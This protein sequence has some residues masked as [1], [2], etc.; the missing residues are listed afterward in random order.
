MAFIALI[1]G[2][3]K[4]TGDASSSAEKVAKLPE[5]TVPIMPEPR[6]YKNLWRELGD[7]FKLVDKYDGIYDGY[8]KYYLKNKKHITR[9]SKRAEPYLHFIV[10]EVK[11]RN[12]PY[13][14]ALLPFVESA[15]YPFAKS[16]ISAI[17]LWQFMPSTGHMFGLNRDWWYEGRQDIHKS[18]N[19]ALNYL[20]KLY[21]QNGNDWLL[22]LASYNGGYGN[23]LKAKR[24][25]RRKNPKGNADYWAI[26]KYLPEE[27]SNY[28]PLLLAISNIVKNQYLYDLDLY[29]IK[30][31]PFFTTIPLSQQ[32]DLQKIAYSTP[33]S[34][35]TIKILNP[36]FLRSATPPK[37]KYKLLL[38]VKS[39]IVFKE[40]IKI[41]P[42]H[43]QVN[44]AKHTI[45]EGESLSVIAEKYNTS[46][47][48]IRKLNRLKNNRIRAGKKL[49][50]P[51]TAK[52]AKRLLKQPRKKYNGKK[53]YHRV[54]HGESLWKIARYYN[55]SSRALCEWNRISIRKAL[56][57]GQRL[58]IRSS[59]Y[60][61]KISYTLLEGD[62]LWKVANKYSVSMV[63]LSNWNG[64]KKSA[65]LQP[66]TKINIWIKG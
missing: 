49:I 11:K 58:E 23:V 28:V 1:S 52:V 63:D 14:I 22:A 40:K 18:T 32:I 26:R 6:V 38:P 5:K 3:V 24:K 57:K 61:K 37:G 17:G 16:Y 27:T 36:G 56:R 42:K 12:M 46:T 31:E 19:A 25:Y 45:S 10:S 13:E 21:K 39:A 33:A 35:K 48:E 43:F 20:Q 55:V 59:K 9:V 44:W 34:H 15:F 30:N 2:C 60:G 62:S 51:V 53:H 41:N 4:M 29:P 7:G 8:T 54:K 65:I 64:I 47:R 66:G 50:I